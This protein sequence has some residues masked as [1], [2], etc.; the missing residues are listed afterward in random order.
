MY[1]IIFYEDK[2]GKSDVNEYIE[3]IQKNNVKD[4]RIKS[5]KI[6]M[7]FDLLSKHGFMLSEPYIKKITNDIW[8]IRPLRDRFLFSY[9]NENTFIVLSHFIKK[10]RKAPKKEIERANRLLNDYKKRRSNNG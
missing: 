8:E 7:F 3:K 9:I 2:N 6:S 5:K 1:N 4:D 10:T